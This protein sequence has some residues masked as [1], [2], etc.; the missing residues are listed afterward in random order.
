MPQKAD[1]TNPTDLTAPVYSLDEKEN[2]FPWANP[3]HCHKPLGKGKAWRYTI[4]CGLHDTT[5]LAKLLE[6]KI[7]AHEEVFDD[8]R[9]G[10]RSRLFDLGFDDNGYPI[11]E[12]FVLSLAC[13][14][15]GQIL[16]SDDGVQILD[17]GGQIDTGG[18]QEPDQ[19]IPSPNS[20][21]TGFD[22]LSR[23]LVQR[24]VSETA[25][26]RQSGKPPPRE[27]LD[28]FIEFVASKCFLPNGI[29]GLVC[30]A[31]CFQ[32]KK[33]EQQPD[34]AKVPQGDDLLN[35]FFIGDLEALSSAW[36]R[37]NIG[38]GLTEYMTAVASTDRSRN[39]LRSKAGLDAAFQAL[40]PERMPQGCWPS[41]HPLA[42]SQQLAVNEI[43]RRFPNGSGLFAVNGPPGTGKTTLLRD[44]VA[45]VV[46]ERAKR[47][48]N[49][50]SSVFAPKASH[51]LG[52]TWVPYYG[53]NEAVTGSAIVVASA[54]N[55]AVENV[56]LELP[57]IKAVPKGVATS[58]DYFAGLATRVLDKPSWGLLAARLGNKTNRTEFLDRFWWQKPREQKEGQG[59]PLSEDCE[60]GL[61]HHL[62]SIQEGKRKPAILWNEAV[63]RL[64]EALDR[65]TSIRKSLIAA[66]KLPARVA[67]LRDRIGKD[68]LEVSRAEGI[69]AE[70][71]GAATHLLADVERLSAECTRLRDRFKEAQLALQSHDAAR[72]GF[73]LWLSTLGRSHRDWWA[74]RCAIEKEVDRTRG[75]CGGPERALAETKVRHA[76]AHRQLTDLNYDLKR[77]QADLARAKSELPALE[78]ALAD[79]MSSLGTHWPAYGADDETREQSSPWA[80]EEWRKAREEVFLAAL[81]VHRAFIEHHPTE[82]LANLGLACDWLQGKDMPE[83][84]ARTALDS[85]CFVVPVISTTFASVPRMFRQMGREGIGWLLID[86][87]G[88]ALP[89]QA[90]GAI[91]RAMRTVVVGDPN[92]LEPV[93]P[94]PAAVEGAFAQH[95]GVERHWWPSDTSCQRLADQ[96]MDIGTWLPDSGMGKLWVGCP[97]RV[98]RRCD[99]P[100]F[101]ISNRVAYDGLMVHG[102]QKTDSSLPECHWID[103]R[104][105][106]GEG[107]W[108]PAEGKAARELLLNLKERYGLGASDIFLVSPFR[109]CANK[110]R[111]M[112]RSLGL[113]PEKTGTVHTTQGKEADV[114]V[115]VLGGNPKKTGAKGWAAKK[116]N[117]LN[118][119]VS[120]AK[121]RLY[122]IGDVEG[123]RKQNH[124]RV[125]AEYIP[126]APITPEAPLLVTRIRGRS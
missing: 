106:D 30:I 45:A 119:A 124:F 42:F 25:G 83:V 80:T 109:D 78:S 88:Q 55:G 99:D 71:R 32:V 91:W 54:N 44:I 120:R 33:V 19:D 100:M 92:Q 68:E 82:M 81:D 5:E 47:L 102:K 115:L 36:I 8:R 111:P 43:L 20:G 97:L 3:S 126:V 22:D 72:P 53:F 98:H 89:Q 39:D 65:E 51:K 113:D 95:Y 104:S 35:S 103:V 13:W 28:G 17:R 116:P 76:D 114:V 40:V 112:A 90:A 110:L 18:L 11:P 105:E 10:G 123:W 96:A 94:V 2:A 23:R 63:K 58:S 125:L 16:R 24:L 62:K 117:L 108:V 31:K 61:R 37:R 34:K 12:S 27:W 56:S 59:H 121:K 93:M 52:D 41:E 46:T 70:H 118:V 50:G 75:E 1:K 64:N 66:S 84:L 38:K 21:Y 86:E 77:K 49:V 7:G 74:R 60:E 69:L 57:G 48:A 107:N 9:D 101:S 73:L 85:L 67:T 87:A 4:Q 6:D 29:I 79:A 15:A 14:S 122:V 26:M